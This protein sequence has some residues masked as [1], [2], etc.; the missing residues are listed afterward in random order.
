[1]KKILFV[2]SMGSRMTENELRGLVE[3]FGEIAHIQIMKDPDTGRSRSFGFV[4]MADEEGAAK[5]ITELN[6]KE[7]DGRLVRVRAA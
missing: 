2:G 5:A 3:P 1:M 7:L 4:E 6:G